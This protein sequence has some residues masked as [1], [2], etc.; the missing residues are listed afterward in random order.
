MTTHAVRVCITDT[1][2]K[3]LLQLRREK[4]DY[5]FCFFGGRVEPDEEPIHAAVREVEEETG[6]QITADE[7]DYLDTWTNEA[8]I[9]VLHYNL[10]RTVSWSDIRTGEDF[11]IAM[12]PY[13]EVAKLPLVHSMQWFLQQY[14]ELP[15]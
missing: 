14:P 3:A 2:G 9:H 5:M 13:A 1:E 10:K 15:A 11:G 12:V 8:G 7:L 6:L 4:G